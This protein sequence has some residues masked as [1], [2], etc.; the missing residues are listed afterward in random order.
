MYKTLALIFFLMTASFQAQALEYSWENEE[1][2][3]VNLSSFEGKPII[4]HFWASWCGPC[5]HEMPD[6][7]QW[8]A[9]HPD[10]EVVMLS[11]DN[12]RA[13]AER[14]FSDRGIKIP[15]NMGSRNISAMGVRGIPS[16]FVMDAKGEIKKRYV[17]GV[18]WANQTRSNEVLSWM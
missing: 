18:D 1:G 10:V 8:I 9:E 4:L 11:L 5:Q 3:A 12:G 2:N 15:V 16:T 13:A 14:F 7:V 17:G 6:L